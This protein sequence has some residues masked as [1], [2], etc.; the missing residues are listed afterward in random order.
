MSKKFPE[1]FWFH[2]MESVLFGLKVRG[3]AFLCVASVQNC[4]A[5]TLPTEVQN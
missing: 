1:T 2:L 3:I 5:E 4:S